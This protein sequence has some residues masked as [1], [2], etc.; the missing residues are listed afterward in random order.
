MPLYE[1]K[2]NKC[3]HVVERIIPSTCDKAAWVKCPRCIRG[4]AKP[5]Q[6][7]RNSFALKGRWPGKGGY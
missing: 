3:D 6:F 4:R 1:Y 5:V 2:C 7:S